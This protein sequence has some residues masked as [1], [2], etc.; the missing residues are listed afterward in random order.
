MAMNS[1]RFRSIWNNTTPLLQKVYGAV[2]EDNA[3]SHTAIHATLAS[4][5]VSRDLHST[6]G[7][8][9]TLTKMGIVA[10]P[11]R[12]YFTRVEIR[13]RISLPA[14]EEVD[15]PKEKDMPDTAMAA[16]FVAAETKPVV[17]PEPAPVAVPANDSAPALDPI[18]RLTKLSAS[19]RTLA[20]DI[21][22]VALDFTE[23]LALIESKTKKL[24]QLRALLKDIA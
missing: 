8:L 2:P 6:Q 7:C 17:T 11:E 5:G 20:D 16:A 19:L 23:Q 4:R 13:G 1:A 14:A 24:E 15:Q 22:A 10:E 9:N 12:G 21:E 18:D 3:V